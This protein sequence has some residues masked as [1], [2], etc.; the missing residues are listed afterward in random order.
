MEWIKLYFM[1][2]ALWVGVCTMAGWMRFSSPVM[3]A[4]LILLTAALFW[5]VLLIRMVQNVLRG[6]PNG[7]I[8]F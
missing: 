1:I 4:G 2:G 5:P 6:D 3:P 7:S 8:W